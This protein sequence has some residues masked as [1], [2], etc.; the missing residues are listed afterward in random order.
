MRT[1]LRQSIIDSRDDRRRPPKRYE[2]ALG[3]CHDLYCCNTHC[4]NLRAQKRNAPRLSRATHVAGFTQDV[5]EESGVQ[6][7]CDTTASAAALDVATEL[8]LAS[9]FLQL[10]EDAATSAF[11]EKARDPSALRKSASHVL[12]KAISRTAANGLTCTGGM[13][14]LS[15]LQFEMLLTGGSLSTAGMGQGAG[16]GVTAP[17]N[18]PVHA[19]MGD[20]EE[21]EGAH[22]TGIARWVPQPIR[23]YLA[24][25]SSQSAGVPTVT[26]ASELMPLLVDVGAGDGGA[27]A[28][29]A[30]RF[31]HTWASEASRAMQLRLR[32]RG[33]RVVDFPQCCLGTT[34]ASKHTLAPELRLLLSQ[35][36][37]GGPPLTQAPCV[38]SCLNVLDR[39]DEPNR[40]LQSLLDTLTA[41]DAFVGEQCRVAG[42]NTRPPRALCL[43][44]VVLP[45]C[46]FVEGWSGRKDPSEG[47]PMDG[48][49]CSQGAP[50]EAAVF[51]LVQR[52]LVPMGFRVVRWTRVPYLCEGDHTTEYYALD[53]A[54]FLLE[55]TVPIQPQ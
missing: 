15:P 25:R 6:H 36:V 26:T 38:M 40:L 18:V 46:P 27:T 43:L 47:L 44:A 13:F 29:L 24:S 34:S 8:A 14:V 28:N 12:A 7:V 19:T 52:V 50:F 30:P 21:E 48:G 16:E 17:R 35:R 49:L 23:K 2:V 53:D 33:Y 9:T 5:S 51:T 42:H 1:L 11:L 39:A 20:G 54:V 22:A 31:E 32:Y 45:W 37:S 4:Y 55:S 3:R 10:H 41:V